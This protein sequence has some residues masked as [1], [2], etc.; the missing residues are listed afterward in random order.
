[1]ISFGIMQG[2]LT[3]S[4]GKG[5]QFFPFDHWEKEFEL[6]A[7]IGINEVEW[8][9]DYDRFEDNPLWSCIYSERLWISS[10]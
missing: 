10:S 8:I 4:Q 3:P 5:I 7:M 1:M 6:G 2:R 9:F